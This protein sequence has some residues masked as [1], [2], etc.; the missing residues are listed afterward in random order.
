[1]DAERIEQLLTA[2]LE[3]RRRAYCPYSG[4][5][6][7]AC[8]EAADGQRFSGVNVENA[9]LGETICAERAAAAA[10]VTA[11]ARRL[12]ACAVVGGPVDGKPRAVQPCGSCRQVLHEL[13]GSGLLVITLGPRIARLGELLPQPFGEPHP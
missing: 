3:A 11:G 5:A 7:G 8:V 2:A 12:K 1:M 13:G 9:A 4:F 10:A 6:V